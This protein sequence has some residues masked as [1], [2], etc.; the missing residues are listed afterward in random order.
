M[1]KKNLKSKLSLK[2]K[3]ISMLNGEETK[4]VKGGVGPTVGCLPWCETQ[5]CPDPLGY[6]C[7]PFQ[8]HSQIVN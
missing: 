4:D 8:C 6:S 5:S 7:G 2:V 1:K 3:D